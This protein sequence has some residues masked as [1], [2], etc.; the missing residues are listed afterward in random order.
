MTVNVVTDTTYIFPSVEVIWGFDKENNMCLSWNNGVICFD[1][2]IPRKV[3]NKHAELLQ[4]VIRQQEYFHKYRN[5]WS[6]VY[7]NSNEQLYYILIMEG[8]EGITI[9][10]N[11]LDGNRL[12][13]YYFSMIKH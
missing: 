4:L 11:R 3:R 2:V 9:W 13:C 5:V 8:K 6:E 1:S 12:P 10:I 7:T